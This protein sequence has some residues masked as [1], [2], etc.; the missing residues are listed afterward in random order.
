MAFKAKSNGQYLMNN[1][2]LIIGLIGLLIIV[3]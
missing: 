3:L 1:M 2:K